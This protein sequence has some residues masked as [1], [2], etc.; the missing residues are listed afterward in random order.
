MCLWRAGTWQQLQKYPYWL[1]RTISM[2]T[3][4]RGTI[5]SLR[6]LQD[7]LLDWSGCSQAYLACL[8]LCLAFL[9]WLAPQ[10]I[11][12]YFWYGMCRMYSYTIARRLIYPH[13][14][15]SSNSK[16]G[17][18]GSNHLLQP[19]TSTHDSMAVSIRNRI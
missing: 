17:V 15:L 19:R 10:S 14:R 8:L 5:R 2:G 13:G 3:G 9:F 11:S 16:E 1:K 18:S 6:G 12:A 4:R 7:R